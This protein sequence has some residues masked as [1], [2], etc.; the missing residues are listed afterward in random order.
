M[1]IK[2]N[3]VSLHETGSIIYFS[4]EFLLIDY[5]DVRLFFLSQ[6]LPGILAR[7]HVVRFTAYGRCRS[8]PPVSPHVFVPHASCDAHFFLDVFKYIGRFTASL[9]KSWR[10]NDNE[11]ED[12]Y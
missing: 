11:K 7:H 5:P 12:H 4:F 1:R 6:L 2:T 3:N 10:N 9:R 8:S